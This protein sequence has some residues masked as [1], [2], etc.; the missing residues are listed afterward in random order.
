LMLVNKCLESLGV[1]VLS[2]AYQFAV[3]A[4][5]ARSVCRACLGLGCHLGL[6]RV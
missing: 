3:I 4:T 1:A 2:P 6:H 5:S